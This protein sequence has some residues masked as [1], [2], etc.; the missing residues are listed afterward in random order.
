MY[1][2]IYSKKFIFSGV[3]HLAFGIVKE[4]LDI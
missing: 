3:T 1:D 4:F 2:H